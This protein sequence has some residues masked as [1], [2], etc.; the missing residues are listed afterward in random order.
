MTND[1]LSRKAAEVM[2]CVGTEWSYAEY[3]GVVCVDGSVAFPSYATDA[4][5]I[6][7]AVRE[8]GLR[9]QYVDEYP[10]YIEICLVAIDDWLWRGNDTDP[11]HA[12]ERALCKALLAAC[13]ERSA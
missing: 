3:A 8:K 10:D 9:F 6:L 13:E 4:T 11:H 7:A 1:E 2:G 12:F 5:A